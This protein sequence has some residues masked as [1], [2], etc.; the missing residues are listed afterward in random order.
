VI[1]IAG[2]RI[3]AEKGQPLWQK[4][5]S[6]KLEA[7]TRS[8]SELPLWRH[9]SWSETINCRRTELACTKWE[10]TRLNDEWDDEAATGRAKRQRF[11]R[12]P[13]FVLS[14]SDFIKDRPQADNEGISPSDCLFNLVL[15]VISEDEFCLSS[16]GS[17]PDCFK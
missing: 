7:T 4:L 11:H 16:Q 13:Y 10:F 17:A 1:G 15:P 9:R 2:I 12:P 3:Q 14:V 8:V 5:H 6:K